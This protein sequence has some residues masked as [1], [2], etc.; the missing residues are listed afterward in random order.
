MR[1]FT[2]VAA[3]VLCSNAVAQ[4]SLSGEWRQVGSDAETQQRHRSIRNAT[5]EIGPLMRTHI[6]RRLRDRTTPPARL[7]IATSGTRVELSTDDASIELV[8]GG[9]AVNVEGRAGRGEAQAQR[10]NGNLV[11]S[12]DGENASRTTTYRLSQ[13]GRQLVLDI[14]IDVQGIS[15]PIRFRVTYERA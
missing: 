6:R 11:L 13:D 1:M 2:L 14:R 15:T 5:E 12:V 3:T 7:R 8:V 9:D 4:P 10:R